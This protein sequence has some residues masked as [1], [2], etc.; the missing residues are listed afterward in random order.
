MVPST[1][2]KT[3]FK[4]ESK[5]SKFWPN[6]NRLIVMPSYEIFYETNLSNF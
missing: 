2:P 4:S 6:C 1:T 5:I 3:L